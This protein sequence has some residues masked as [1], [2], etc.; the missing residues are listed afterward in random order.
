M[1]RKIFIAIDLDDRAKNFIDKKVEKLKDHQLSTRW[2]DKENYHITLSFLGYLEDADLAEISLKISESLKG[3][4]IFDI[5]LNKM[6]LAPDKKKPKMVWLIGDKNQELID[7]RH[8]IEES[9]NDVGVEK[10]EFRPHINLGKIK[11]SQVKEIALENV[12]KIER[13]IDLLIP[14]EGIKIFE[15]KVEKR[16]QKYYPI[17]SIEFN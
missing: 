14:V 2:I 10:K 8:R 13:N 17:D 12:E 6:I 15:S 7:L 5:H 3:I 4:E 1:Q 9:V 11:G 16:R